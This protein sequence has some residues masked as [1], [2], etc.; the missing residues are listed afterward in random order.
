MRGEITASNLNEI[1]PQFDAYLEG[2]KTELVT[3][4]DFA[5][6]EANAKNC[7]ETAKRIE[8]LQ[9]NIFG[10]MVS[11]NE[12]NSIL[13]DYKEAFN[14]IGLRLE[15]SID[16]DLPLL[17]SMDGL[18]LEGDI[19][20]EHKLV[21]QSLIEQISANKLDAHYTVQM[22]QQML[23]TGCKKILFMASDG[24]KENCH[25]MWYEA[26]PENFSRLIS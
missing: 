26:K 1:I 21:S 8:A 23:V 16:S 13:S 12:V 2:V 18:T 10:Q 15:K 24:T 25:W 19:G 20:F 4:Q 9:E 5:D 7:R 3:D 14:K 22:D 17:A 11:V 6:A